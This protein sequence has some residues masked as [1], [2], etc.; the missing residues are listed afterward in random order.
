MSPAW[1][2]RLLAL[3]LP[4]FA[5]SSSV[6]AGPPA[7]ARDQVWEAE[8]AFARSMA[9]RDLVAFGRF[10]ADDAVFFSGTT[11][12]HGKAAVV[13]AWSAFFQ[14][15][16]APFSW[17]PDQVE[18]LQS[19]T[20]AV[21]TGP[22]RDPDGKVVARF[23]SVWRLEAPGQWRVIIDKGSPPS[24]GPHEQAGKSGAD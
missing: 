14:G 12:S 16:S 20:L 17:E 22:V 19:G 10:I 7:S 2:S 24:P 6:V 11:V 13:E 18:V 1:S 23:N 15:E 9:K 3:A 8:K 21:S 4:L 5:W